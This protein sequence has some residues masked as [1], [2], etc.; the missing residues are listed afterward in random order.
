MTYFLRTIPGMENHL[1]P[2]GDVIRHHFIPA[3]TGGHVVNDKERK[4]LSLPPRLGV[5][6]GLKN[7]VEKTELNMTTHATPRST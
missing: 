7:F 5:G 4:L 6:L 1:Q 2:L 3:I